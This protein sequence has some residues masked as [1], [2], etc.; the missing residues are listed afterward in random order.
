[1]IFHQLFTSSHLQ[2]ILCGTSCMLA[3]NAQ[4]RQRR[5]VQ[6]SIVSNIASFVL[7]FALLSWSFYACVVV[8]MPTL[9]TTIFYVQWLAISAVP[10]LFFGAGVRASWTKYANQYRRPVSWFIRI[11]FYA[12]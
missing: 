12:I 3:S 6:L 10:T 5:T 4:Y 2:Y 11:G 8:P 9:R 7:A 1:M